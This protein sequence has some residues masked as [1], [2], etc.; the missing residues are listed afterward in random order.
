MATKREEIE[1]PRSCLNRAEDD[2]HIF[3]IVSHDRT[4]PGAVRDWAH[5]AKGQGA[6]QEKVNGA[7]EAALQMEIWQRKHPERVKVPD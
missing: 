1:D 3:V 7:M 4:G 6:S 5:R 2:E